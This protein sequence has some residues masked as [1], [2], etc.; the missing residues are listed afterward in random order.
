MGRKS[1]LCSIAL[2]LWPLL[3][4]RSTNKALLHAHVPHNLMER[5][6]TTHRKKY[7]L[8]NVVK[9][10]GILWNTNII[11]QFR[12]CAT[13]TNLGIYTRELFSNLDIYVI[14]NMEIIQCWCL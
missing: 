8:I 9:C 12:N 5:T 10:I 3:G 14:Y 7:S 1:G 4:L 2:N 11:F 13:P 6:N